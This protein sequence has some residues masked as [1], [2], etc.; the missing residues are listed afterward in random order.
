MKILTGT[1]RG[2]AIDYRPNPHLRP[3]SDKARKAVFDMLQGQIENKTCLDLFSGTGAVGFEALS[4]GASSV[5]FVEMDRSQAG[6]IKDNLSKLRL[7]QKG[8][9]V[10]GDVVSV[11]ERLSRDKEGYDFVF[12]DPPYEMGMGEKT[13]A[14]LARSSIL[15]KGS[16]IILECRHSEDLPDAHEDFTYLKDKLYGDTRIVIYRRS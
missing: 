5:T 7:S 11:I 1:L 4:Q 3:T 16:L 8:K 6:A 13:M 2:R 14:A 10:I 12:M 15:K 9:V